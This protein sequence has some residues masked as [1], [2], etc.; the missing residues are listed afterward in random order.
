[1]PILLDEV[2]ALLAA[3]QRP[4]LGF[5]TGATFAPFLR[6]LGDD[7]ANARVAGAER[8]LA[9]HLDEY[10][11]FP[12]D[13]TGGMVHELTT[14]CPALAAMLARGTFLPVP[15]DGGAASLR[16]HAERLQRA[17]GIG[18]QLLGVGRNGHLAFNEPGTPFDLGFHTATLAA[19][20]RDD[21]RS[22]FAPAEPPQQA[23][24]AG[25]ATILAARRLV[26][27]AFGKAKAAAVAAML[28]GAIDPAC[29]ASVVRRHG[30][31]LVLL[32]RAAAAG[33]GESPRV[34]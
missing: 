4:L 30:S 10:L 8:L 31:V 12:P 21:A 6:A 24:T 9:T 20:T 3:Q 29:P 2:R 32:D 23:V 34:A 26:V 19:S 14:S 18:L 22:R 27:C 28:H 15:Y 5:A 7:V 11:G 33:L 16:A 13:R 17:G 1:V 25:P